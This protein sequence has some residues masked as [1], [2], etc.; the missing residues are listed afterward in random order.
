MRKYDRIRIR[1]EMDLFAYPHC[2]VKVDQISDASVLSG[3]AESL[4]SCNV[5]AWLYNPCVF[6]KFIV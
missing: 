5:S 3:L 1:L 2:A 6:C 4:S